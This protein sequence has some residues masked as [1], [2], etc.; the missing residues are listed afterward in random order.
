MPIVRRVVAQLAA[1]AVAVLAAAVG[2]QVG[3]A[4]P[5]ETGV[6]LEELGPYQAAPTVFRRTVRA[7]GTLARLTLYWREVAPTSPPASWDPTDPVDPNYRWS[8]F[9]A[10]LRATA[11]A[12]LEPLVTILGAP[13]W[14]QQGHEVPAPGSYLPDVSAFADFATAAARRYS[15]D[16]PD[17]P[18]VKYFQAW[19][20]QNLSTYLE[21]QL[22]NGKPVAPAHYRQMLN[23]FADAVHGVLP[24]DV[25]IAGGLAPFRDVTPTVMAQNKDWGPLTFLRSLL[26]V[27][28]ALRPTCSAVTKAD[29]WAVHPYTS[30]NATHHA[31]LPDDVSLG[32]LPDVQRVL[33]AAAAAGHLVSTRPRQLWVTEFSWDTS[34]PDTQGVPVERM[35]RWVPEAL[36]QM[37]RNGVS[38]AIWLQIRDEPVGKSFYQSGLYFRGSTLAA[39]TPKPFLAGFRFPFVAYPSRSRVRIW[40]RLPGS[41]RG[42]V[43]VEQVTGRSWHPLAEFRSDAWGVFR[44]TVRATARGALRARLAGQR[45]ASLPFELTVPQPADLRVNPFGLPT[46]LEPPKR[47]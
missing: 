3:L 37:W 1:A 18:R 31:V 43:L 20:E 22:V 46:L 34:P 14:A 24:D 26:C 32:D 8:E 29:V 39:D 13:R 47:P 21:P 38:A 30:G 6:Y 25:V 28:R 45:N 41:V 33:K 9:D 4:Q 2:A 19:N 44:G 12:G 23:A 27:S 40:G 42:R 17:V 36:Y 10:R 15:G 5:I 7:G 35:R 16:F 11:A